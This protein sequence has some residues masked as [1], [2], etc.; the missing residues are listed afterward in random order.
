MIHTDYIKDNID[1]DDL[2]MYLS[3]IFFFNWYS[4]VNIFNIVMCLLIFIKLRY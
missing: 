4:D 1:I 2:N 3:Y